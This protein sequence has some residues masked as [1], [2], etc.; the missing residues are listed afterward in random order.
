MN[1]KPDIKVL[2]ATFPLPMLL[3]RVGLERYA[4]CNNTAHSDLPPSWSIFQTSNRWLYKDQV[5]GEVG[6]EIGLLAKIKNLDPWQDYDALLKTYQQVAQKSFTPA[7]LVQAQNKTPAVQ[8][9]PP[10]WG[11]C[12]PEQLQRLSDS[13]GVSVPGLQF[14]HERGVL[15]FGQWRGY[16]VYGLTDLSQ[17]LT[18]VW[19][20]DGKKFPATSRREQAQTHYLLAGSTRNWPLGL[21]G[22][23][24]SELIAMAAGRR[25]FLALHQQVVE[26]QEV[27]KVAPVAM[28]FWADFIAQDALK[29][30][31]GKHIRL[32]LAPHLTGRRALVRWNNQLRAAGAAKIDHLNFQSLKTPQGELVKNL[33]QLNQSSLPGLNVFERS[34]SP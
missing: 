16:S 15:L 31:Q 25:D 19:R 8:P 22:A 2:T 13:L 5:T 7:Q 9:D 34:V 23:G 10:V 28:L 4:T 21:V 33:A 18:V 14:A 32:F 24:E 17:R 20:L 29:H 1:T 6:N 27:G 11:P 26:R 30:F 3:K 12:T